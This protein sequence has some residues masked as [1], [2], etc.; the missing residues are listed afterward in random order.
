MN[1]PLKHE[2]SSNTPGVCQ[3][4]IFKTGLATT[5]A[6]LSRLAVVV[7]VMGLLASPASAAV[8]RYFS[9]TTTPASVAAG[10]DNTHSIT[11]ENCNGSLAC[12]GLITTASQTMK[13]ATVEVPAGFT[14]ISPLSVSATGGKVW[15]AS[16]SGSTIELEKSGPDQL[17]PGESVT[18]SFDATA[19]CE[20]GFYE[21]TSAAFNADDFMSTPYDL[22]GVQP[23]VEVTGGCESVTID[24]KPGSDPNS[25]NLKSKGNIPV[26]VLTT[27]TFYAPDVNFEMVQFGPGGATE[28]H[29]R[30]HV[31]DVDEDGDTDIVLHFKTQ[32]TGIQCSDTEATLSGETF[33]G[34]AFTATDAIKIVKCD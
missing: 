22:A 13:S 27:D 12:S 24:I 5:F 2:F 8:D 33:G 34:Q 9:A 20:A 11:I 32:E 28:S 23:E 6:C 1:T 19:P 16:L 21:W 25:I 17:D 31:E 7:A 10:S 3:A 29:G 26:A 14:V 30:A 15:I 4:A 18:V